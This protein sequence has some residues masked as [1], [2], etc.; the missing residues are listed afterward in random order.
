MKISR[1]IILILTI[2]AIIICCLFFNLLG[3]FALIDQNY[4]KCGYALIISTVFLIS[5]YIFGFLKKII[6]T[7]LL[8]IIGT[9]GYI[10]SIAQLNK[11]PNALV[12]RENIEKIIQNHIYTVSVTILLALLVFFNFMLDENINKRAERKLQKKDRLERALKNDEKIL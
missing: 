1:K 2:P 9:I 10:Y 11:I 7:V 8:N 12:P 4:E 6:P 3:G 5:S